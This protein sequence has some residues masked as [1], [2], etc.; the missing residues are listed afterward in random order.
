MQSKKK[1]LNNGDCGKCDDIFNRYPGFH[2]GLRAWFKQVQKEDPTAHISA[3]GRGKVEQ[4]AF[5]EKGASRAHYGQSAHNY[6]AAIDIFRL[7]H[8][9]ADWSPP[10][11]RSSIQPRV[12]KHNA[13]IDTLVF[14]ITWY[15]MPGSKFFELP[16]VEVSGWKNLN[17][18]LVE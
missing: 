16:H 18:K 7:I 9:G 5:F 12:E 4:E 15:G 6:N 11:F 2:P 10:W 14:K 8:T 17:L 1:H 13:Q 3:A